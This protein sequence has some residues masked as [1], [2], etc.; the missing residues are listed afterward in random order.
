MKLPEELNLKLEEL[1]NKYKENELREAYA[2]ISDRYMNEKRRGNTL[3]EKEIDVI[4]YAN[5]RMPAT[6][7]AVYTAFAKSLKYINECNLKTLLDVGA[8]TGAATWGISEFIEFEKITCL[9]KEKNMMEFGKKLMEANKIG[10]S[11]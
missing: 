9:E 11:Y 1:S 4:A 10:R 2:G 8:G 5:A 3:L 6:Y 7:S